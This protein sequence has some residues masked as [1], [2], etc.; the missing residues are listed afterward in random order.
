MA[1][2]EIKTGRLSEGRQPRFLE[3]HFSVRALAEIWG[4]SPDSIQKLFEREPGVLVIGDDGSRSKR[5]YHTLRIPESVAE[6]VHRRKSNPDLTAPRGKAYP[7]ESRD[8][9]L[10]TTTDGP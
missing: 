1:G 8:H 10:L 5:G 7:P 2:S 4:L 9:Q 3:R 6:R